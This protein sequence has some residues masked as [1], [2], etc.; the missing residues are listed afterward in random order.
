VLFKPASGWIRRQKERTD[1]KGTLKRRNEAENK[2]ESA[3][4][5]SVKEIYISKMMTVK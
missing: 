1:T 2:G 5:V 3:T 4:K